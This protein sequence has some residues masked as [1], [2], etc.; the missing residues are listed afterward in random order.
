MVVFVKYI[1]FIMCFSYL[2]NA[3]AIDMLTLS[4]IA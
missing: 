3:T 1:V 4:L 2:F